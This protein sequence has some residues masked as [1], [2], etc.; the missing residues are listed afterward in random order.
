MAQVQK[1]DLANLEEAINSVA[2]QE[3][4]IFDIAGECSNSL[5]EE[6]GLVTLFDSLFSLQTTLMTY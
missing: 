4:S 3:D 5:D 6:E 1:M 2:K